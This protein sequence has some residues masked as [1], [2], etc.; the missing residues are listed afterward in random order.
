MKRAFLPIPIILFLLT[1]CITAETKARLDA[2]TA[3]VATARN[4]LARAKIG[5]VSPQEIARL[6][7]RV[8]T[9]ESALD[10]VKHE[11]L[12]ERIG[13]G[14][15]KGKAAVDAVNPLVAGALPGIGWIL[16]LVSAGL[17]G[18]SAAFGKKPMVAGNAT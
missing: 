13:D 10:D 5:N 2:L 12:R 18:L 6:Q 9:A 4:E 15:G 7:E 14:A 8:T 1:G 16:T 17:G 3:E 11:A